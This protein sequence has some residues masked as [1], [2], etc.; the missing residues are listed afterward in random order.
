MHSVQQ[1]PR[2]NP[3]YLHRPKLIKTLV[4]NRPFLLP[5][6][7]LSLASRVQCPT[8]SLPWPPPPARPWPLPPSAV[9]LPPSPPPPGC[10]SHQTNA[11]RHVSCI[12]WL[13][14]WKRTADTHFTEAFGLIIAYDKN[15]ELKGKRLVKLSYKTDH[16]LNFHQTWS[17]QWRGKRPLKVLCTYNL[18]TTKK[19]VQPIHYRENSTRH[20]RIHGSTSTKQT[21]K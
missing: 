10:V 15:D 8:A 11:D 7:P 13:C 2:T 12:N 16:S 20:H 1:Q 21:A 19:M 17:P 5:L 9:S 3:Y 4:H 6:A 18:V 14:H